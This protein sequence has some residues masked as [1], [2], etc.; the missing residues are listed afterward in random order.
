MPALLLL[1]LPFHFWRIRKAGGLVVPRTPNEDQAVRGAMVPAIPNLIVRELAV[2]A[3]VAAVILILSALLDAPIG[4]KANPG[5]SPNPTKAPWY[6]AGFQELLFHFHPIVAVLL[7][8]AALAA[9]L[10]FV[11]YLTGGESSAG[12]WFASRAGRK[13]ALVAA[14]AA[15]VLT[16]AAILLDGFVADR[17]GWLTALPAAVR[18][19]FL[20]VGM[21]IGILALIYRMPIIIAGAT[22]MESVQ[23]VFVFLSTS[24]AL[25]TL[26][27]VAFRGIGMSLAWPWS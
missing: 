4:D 13:A 25:L 9:G 27:C 17:A 11:P 10:V 22:R 8:P 15:L 3:L 20:P 24:W 18:T 1:L 26:T 7:L 16:P 5:L 12:V 14:A 6:F 21:L 2:A 23:A 19:G